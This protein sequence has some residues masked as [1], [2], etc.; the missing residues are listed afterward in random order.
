MSVVSSDVFGTLP[1]GR[2]VH[3]FTLRSDSVRL[4]V[5]SLGGIITSLET[6]DRQGELADIVLGFDHLQGYINK[7]PYFGAVVGRVANRIAEGKFSIDGKEYQLPINN[8]PNSLHGGLK[9]FDKMLW[10]SEIL[11]NGVR[12]SMTSADGEEGYPGE[13]KVWVTYSLDGAVLAIN[14]KAQ[15]TKTT[16]VN[17][18]N[19]SYF[20]LAG[21]VKKLVLSNEQR[22]QH[23]NAIV[24]HVL[25]GVSINKEI[26]Y[27]GF[28][29]I[30][31]HE[32]SIEAENYLPVDK[33]S[34]PTGE[35]TSV[36]NTNF[37]LRNLVV[38]GD[39]IANKLA[40]GFDHNFCLNFS[41]QRSPCARVYHRPSGRLL[42][43]ETTQP[44]VQF[45]T[46]NFLDG[47]LKG[48]G[49]ATYPKHSAFCLETQNWPDAVNKANFPDA[50]LRPGEEY[51][52]TT[53]FKF[54]VL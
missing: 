5:L 27:H 18:T 30:Y 35:I 24:M 43:I 40:G 8:G 49:G 9:G 45:Y 52:H 17:L 23:N 54:S 46:A 34:I 31:D 25:Y 22:G 13:L 12:L 29:N 39:Q 38:L 20:N 32:V 37:D 44:G 36:E 1:D 16:P 48:K 4:S 47:S 10:T 42:E 14:Y 28:P 53:W 26:L 7:H 41:K 11:S 15:T 33:T 6:R 19:H 21:H 3:R 2:L 50:L 51:D